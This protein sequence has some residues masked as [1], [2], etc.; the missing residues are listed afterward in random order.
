MRRC[1][2]QKH[3]DSHLTVV[4]VISPCVTA[5]ATGT[6]NHHVSGEHAKVEKKHMN[7]Y[8]VCFMCFGAPVEKDGFVVGGL[9]GCKRKALSPQQ[10]LRTS[11]EVR[12]PR[13]C[14]AFDNSCG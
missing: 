4:D 2:L 8:E 13:F 10:T 1:H 6:A 12:E 7:I 5:N 3:R 11:S 9:L 14:R